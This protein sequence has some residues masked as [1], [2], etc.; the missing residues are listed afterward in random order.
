MEISVVDVVTISVVV[1]CCDGSCCDGSCCCWIEKL[2]RNGH[3]HPNGFNRGGIM[4]NHIKLCWDD[5]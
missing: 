3:S 1:G 4:V 5:K 2:V